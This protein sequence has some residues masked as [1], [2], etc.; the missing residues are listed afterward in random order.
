VCVQ[1]LELRV[2]RRQ[3]PR[4]CGGYVVYGGYVEPRDLRLFF[5][6]GIWRVCG[7]EGPQAAPTAEATRNAPSAKHSA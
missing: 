6:C 7:A 1:G 2:P 4:V 3:Q 5:F